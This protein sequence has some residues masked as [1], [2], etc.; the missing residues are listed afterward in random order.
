MPKPHQRKY[1][2]LLDQKRDILES[3]TAVHGERAAM[4]AESC[5][6][7]MLLQREFLAAMTELMVRE[8][9]SAKDINGFLDQIHEPMS[10]MVARM[11]YL[12]TDSMTDKDRE[13][14]TRTIVGFAKTVDRGIHA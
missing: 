7:V 4:V 12:M 8:Q 2:D 6:A 14:L 10:T 5:V 9:T 1:S 13:D 3:I 11:V